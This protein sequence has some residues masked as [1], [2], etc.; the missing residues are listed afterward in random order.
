MEGSSLLS[1]FNF[2]NFLFKADFPFLTRFDSALA[3]HEL[4]LFTLDACFSAVSRA[5]H[6]PSYEVSDYLMGIAHH[7][8]TVIRVKVLRNVLLIISFNINLTFA[9]VSVRVLLPLLDQRLSIDETAVISTS[10]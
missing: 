7:V 4:V 9:P 10:R 1:V 6:F 8:G 3:L 2:V 5:P